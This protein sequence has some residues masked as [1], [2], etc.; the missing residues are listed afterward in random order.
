VTASGGRSLTPVVA[1]VGA[2][3]VALTVLYLQTGIARHKPFLWDEGLEWSVDCAQSALSMV[4]DGAA[5][6]CSPS[7]A[8][9]L[10]L[11]QLARFVEAR[12]DGILL[13]YRTISFASVAALL[14]LLGGFLGARLGPACAVA[15]LASLVGQPLLH[16]YATQSRPYAL[17]LTLFALLLLALSDAAVSGAR[18]TRGAAAVA[19]LAAVAGSLVL[20]T[21]AAQG[22][23]ACATFIVLARLQ[24]APLRSPAILG[25]AA[26]LAA[27]AAA[28]AYYRSLSYCLVYDP[29]P[30]SVWGAQ[31]PLLLRRVVEL[32][33][34]DGVWGNA[35]LLAGCAAPF[36]AWRERSRS[37]A[38][39]V[40]WALGLLVLGQLAFTVALG[41]QVAW[42]DYYFLPRLFLHLVVCRAVLIALGVWVL[43]QAIARL[44]PGVRPLAEGVAV[45]LGL[46]ALGIG[47][48]LLRQEASDRRD[49]ATRPAG[50]CLRWELPLL[51]VDA[52]PIDHTFGTN[53]IVDASREARRCGAARASEPRV[54]LTRP[55]GVR[56]ILPAAPPGAR[57]LRQCG[58]VVVLRPDR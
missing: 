22:A 13:S 21:G 43:T 6:Q 50:P 55:G 45:A 12:D 18:P 38:A 54:L 52:D 10:L 44:R 9:Y 29:G 23:A 49:A 36:W 2:C 39:A 34:T 58:R 35:L 37:R 1:W 33:W 20:L 48:V 46:G 51:V 15:A 28:A 27:C 57:L 25:A 32:L 7:P 41:A 40:V 47:L 42:A 14:C 31:G 56:E 26:L 16:D 24:R 17:A 11:K 8:Y 3:A 30:L 5:N 53:T 19:V 4:R